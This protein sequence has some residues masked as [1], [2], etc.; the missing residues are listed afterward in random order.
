MGVDSEYPRGTPKSAG[1]YLLLERMDI[2][3]ELRGAAQGPR[4]EEATMG[5]TRKK[6][7]DAKRVSSEGRHAGDD[8][9]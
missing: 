8:R 4:R 2:N 7:R 3:K 9:G 1:P 6:L 5:R